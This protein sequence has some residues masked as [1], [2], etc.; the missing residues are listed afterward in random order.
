MLLVSLPRNGKKTA[1]NQCLSSQRFMPM[2][3]SRSFIALALTFRSMIHFEFNFVYSVKQGSKFVPA[4][5]AED[6]TTLS[7]TE[8]AWRSC[9]IGIWEIKDIKMLQMNSTM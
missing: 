9:H 2:F 3:S 7:P 8:L 4:S 6:D 5:F 1:K